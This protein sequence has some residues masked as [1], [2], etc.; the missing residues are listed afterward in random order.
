MKKLVNA[1]LWFCTATLLAQCA[2]IGLAAWKGNFKRETMTRV[3]ALLNGIDIQGER[4]KG[5]YISSRSVP[6][7]TYEDILIAKSSAAL[8]LDDK[9][10]SLDRFQRVLDDRQR[11]LQDEID[12][13]DQRRAEFE[14][15]LQN[16]KNGIESDNLKE[17]QKILTVLSPEKAQE[18]LELMWEKG[19]KTDVASIIRA[20]PADIQKKVLAE[21]NK[22][23]TL[24]EILS[25]IRN[26]DPLKSTLDKAAETPPK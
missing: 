21:F 11:K 22:K 9:S 19:E 16:R 4:L 5:A 1:F 15:E 12:R 17:T 26:G 3:I 2:I 10:K 7:P 14:I 18:Q 20:M 25:E 6:A 23:E 24:S 13:F 8:E